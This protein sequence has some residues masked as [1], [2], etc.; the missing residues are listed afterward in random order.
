MAKSQLCLHVLYIP[1]AVQF[2][3][4]QVTFQPCFRWKENNQ[5]P[6]GSSRQTRVEAIFS[7]SS[8]SCVSG[9]G[10]NS[11]RTA[12]GLQQ[13]FYRTLNCWCSVQ[14]EAPVGCLIFDCR[15][16]SLSG[17]TGCDQH[18][19]NLSFCEDETD[20]KSA[21]DAMQKYEYEQTSD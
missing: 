11:A 13:S 7:P 16:V 4:Q 10:G 1:R 21:V 5:C 14:P 9:L 17:V 2:I 18:S 6:T 12:V 3:A 19:F 8:L 20:R 15:S